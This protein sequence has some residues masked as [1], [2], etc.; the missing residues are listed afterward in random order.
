MTDGEAPVI[1]EVWRNQS[2]LSL[3]LLPGPLWTGIIA[4]DSVISVG[5]IE[6]FDI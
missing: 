3:A 2:T 5:Q 6:V 1:L 4:H